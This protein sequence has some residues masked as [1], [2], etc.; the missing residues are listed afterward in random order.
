M[1][2]G[3]FALRRL[4]LC[5]DVDGF[6]DVATLCSHTRRYKCWRRLDGHLHI[7]SLFEGKTIPHLSCPSLLPL[8]KATQSETLSSLE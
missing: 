1:I 2:R 4:A 3:R 6:E 7:I 8:G 5:P